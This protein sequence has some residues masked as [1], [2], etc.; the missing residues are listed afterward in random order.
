MGMKSQKRFLILDGNALL[1]RAWHAIPP[2]TAVDGTVVNAVYGFGNIIEKMR[3]QFKP[4]YMAVAWDLKGP[5]FRHEAYVAYKAQREKKAD[6]LYAQIPM[7]QELLACYGVP[8]LSAKGYEADDIIATLA[9]RYAKEGTDVIAM[10]GDMDL[11]QLVND[12]IH[13][14]AFIKGISETKEYDPKAVK[15]RYG[16]VAQQMVY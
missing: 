1:H 4:D 13:V 10:S 2:L 5:T 3:E 16:F 15:E 14:I 9:E 8:S 7:I 6:E 12:K 11:L